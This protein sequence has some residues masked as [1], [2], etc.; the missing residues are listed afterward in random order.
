MIDTFW[1]AY[2]TTGKEMYLAKAKSLANTF[3]I[4]QKMHNGD[5]PTHFTEHKMNFWLNNVVYPA[6]VMMNLQRNL[7]GENNKNY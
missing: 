4:V 6:K 5:Y 2:D 7:E 1:E 3:L